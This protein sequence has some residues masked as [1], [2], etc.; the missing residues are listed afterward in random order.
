MGLF[1][2]LEQVNEFIQ[3]EI[4]TLPG[5]RSV[6]TSVSIDNFKYDVRVARITSGNNRGSQAS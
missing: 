3:R 6:K 2:S 4:R 5:I 1:T